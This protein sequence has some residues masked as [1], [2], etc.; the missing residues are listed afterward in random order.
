MKCR[1]T[2]TFLGHL[3]IAPH[4]P[5]YWTARHRQG[6]RSA[7]ATAQSRAHGLRPVAI[8]QYVAPVCRFNCVNRRNPCEYIDLLLI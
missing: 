2:L 3:Y 4:M 5:P 1:L 6:Q 7:K 8:E